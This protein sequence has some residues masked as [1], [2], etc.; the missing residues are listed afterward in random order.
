MSR[1]DSQ[2]ARLARLGFAD[3]TAA[4]AVVDAWR[5]RGTGEQVELALAELQR[6][7]DPDLALV[8]LNRLASARPGVFAELGAD[9][10]FARR[11]IAVL[12]ASIALNQHL[13]THPDDVDA[14][15]GEVRRRPLADLRAELLFAVGA[16]PGAA[17]PVAE[18]ARSDDL[19]RAYRRALL[20]IAA[21]DLTAADVMAELPDVAA[22][23]A[24][25]A[26][27]TVDTALA[28]A[29]GE[30]PGWENCRIGIVALGKTGARE[31]NYV[32][33]VDVLY[34]AEPALD[35][36]GEPVC[37]AGEA[38]TVATMTDPA[39]EEK[40]CCDDQECLGEQLIHCDQGGF[41]GTYMLPDVMVHPDASFTI[42]FTMSTWEPYHVALMSATFR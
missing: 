12:G 17:A 42:T 20:R 25:L 18:P 4:A 14:L 15:V 6:A 30:V 7:A 36:A 29:R 11:L 8:G 41:F 22:E 16:D 31:L 24:D 5:E 34:L 23:L 10:G 38:V 3:A 27:A 32:S 13:G 37:E 1:I 40:Y 21:R 2:P 19:R 33:D 39:F 35:A 26:D 9:P 28:L